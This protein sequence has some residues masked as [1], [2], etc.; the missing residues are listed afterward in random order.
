MSVFLFIQTPNMFLLL[1]SSFNFY[2]LGQKLHS[3]SFRAISD[4]SHPSHMKL[5]HV[6]ITFHGVY[7]KSSSNELQLVFMMYV[8]FFSSFLLRLKQLSLIKIQFDLQNVYP[9][10]DHMIHSAC[11]ID[12]YIFFKQYFRNQSYENKEVT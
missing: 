5:F 10:A 11:K 8:D 7:I 9:Q 1:L 3:S 12:I 2:F 6:V 4:I